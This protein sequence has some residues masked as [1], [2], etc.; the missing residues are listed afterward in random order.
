MKQLFAILTPFS[1]SQQWSYFAIAE[2]CD[3]QYHHGL[4]EVRWG[5]TIPLAIT[6]DSMDNTNTKYSPQVDLPCHGC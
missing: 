5:T 2:E 1:Q 3:E 4:A 6:I